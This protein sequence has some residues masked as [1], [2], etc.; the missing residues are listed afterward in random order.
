MSEV[1]IKV[2]GWKCDRCGHEWIPRGP[3]KPIVCPSCMSP[4][5]DMK[6]KED[7]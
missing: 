5:W 2:K 6:R 7:N 3:K 1:I 4:Y